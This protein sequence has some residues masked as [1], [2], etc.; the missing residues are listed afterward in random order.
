MFLNMI[1]PVSALT[2][3][4]EMGLQKIFQGAVFSR[5]SLFHLLNQFFFSPLVLKSGRKSVNRSVRD[6]DSPLEMMES[7]GV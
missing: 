1:H 2:L 4:K 7:S 5:C 6:W 3:F